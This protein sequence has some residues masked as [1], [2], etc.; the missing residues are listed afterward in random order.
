MRARWTATAAAGYSGSEMA[1]RAAAGLLL[2]GVALV[3]LVLLQ[4][5]Q[6]VYI[7]V[8]PS[9]TMPLAPHCERLG[10]RGNPGKFTDDPGL[11]PTPSLPRWVGA[12]GTRMPARKGKMTMD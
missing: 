2:C 8:C 6:S 1:S 4:G 9:G 7:Q 12:A 10:W 5:T 11:S 3:F